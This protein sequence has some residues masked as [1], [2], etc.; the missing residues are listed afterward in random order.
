MDGGVWT[1]GRVYGRGCMDGGVWT[2]GRVYGRVGGGSAMGTGNDK[3]RE[4]IG[5]PGDR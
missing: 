2:G 4:G 3:S 1:G 5:G